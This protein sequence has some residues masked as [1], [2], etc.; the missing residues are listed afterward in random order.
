MGLCQQDLDLLTQ[1]DTPTICNVIELFNIRP[2]NAGYMDRRIQAWYPTMAPI[3]GYAATATYRAGL[4]LRDGDVYSLLDHQ[5]AAFEALDGQ[6]LV[7]FQDLDDPSA[8]ASFGE[9]MCSTYKAYG[10][11]GLVTSGTGRDIEQVRTLDFPVF[12]DG[13]ICSHG[14]GH[15]VDVGVPVRVGGLPVFNGDLLHADGNG[16][17]NLPHQI[18][19]QTAHA[20]AEYIAAEEIVLDYL[21]SGQLTPAGL[22]EARAESKSRITALGER[23]R[24]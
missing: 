19:S 20:C 9:V 15:T 22:A 5:V 4:A 24:E 2:R 3:V 7:V 17:T 23:L 14:Y 21:K 1:Y 8:A 10:A 16:V 18:A 11:V 13:A 6:A 12:A